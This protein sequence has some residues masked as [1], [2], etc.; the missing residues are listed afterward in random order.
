[1]AT[2]LNEAQVLNAVYDKLTQ[3][4]RTSGGSGGGGGTSDASAANQTTEIARLTS[5]LTEL[6][7]LNLSIL[8]GTQTSADSLSFTPASDITALKI[9][10]TNGDSFETF[11]NRIKIS[12]ADP[13]VPSDYD[14][15]NEISTD[16]V[17]GQDYPGKVEYR[18][19]GSTL[20]TLLYTY[21]ISNGNVRVINVKRI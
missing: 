16:T 2:L 18:F 1:M 6:I 13:L 7:A 3:S 21:A 8:K 20:V 15:I 14:E 5:I 19:G 17:N 12:G 9:A 10:A 4:L 11:E